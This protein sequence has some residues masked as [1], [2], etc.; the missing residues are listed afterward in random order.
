MVLAVSTTN[1]VWVPRLISSGS[2][3]A[4]TSKVTLRPSTAVT[5]TVIST[6]AP[7]SVGARCL[8]ATSTPTESSPASACSRMRLRHVYSMS[9]LIRGVAF[10]RRSAAR[11]R[12]SASVDRGGATARRDQGGQEPVLATRYRHGG[13]D[14]AARRCCRL[15]HLRGCARHHQGQPHPG[16]FLRRQAQEHD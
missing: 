13:R 10:D 6:V 11:L 15:L 3:L 12:R 2:S 1:R 4:A 5:R 16:E 8:T 7:S 9:P 14:G